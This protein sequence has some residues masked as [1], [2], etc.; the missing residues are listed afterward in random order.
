MS[1]EQARGE[2]VDHRTDIWALGVVLYE[3]LTGFSPFK[4]EYDQA[5]LYSIINEEQE[6]L[7]G[8]CSGVPNKDERYQHTDE[9]L[10]DLKILKKQSE[11]QISTTKP[12]ISSASKRKRPRF[13]PGIIALGVLLILILLY[14]YQKL[15]FHATDTKLP[16]LYN[17]T[18]KQVTFSEDLEE[19]PA[20]FPDGKRLV[21]CRETDR[22]K[23]IFIKNLKTGEE[24][25]LSKGD[26]DD[27]QPTCS[28]GGNIILFVRSNLPAGKLEPGDVYGEHFDGD[29]WKFELNSKKE[30]KLIEN[31]F[32]PSFSPDGFKIAFDAS[33]AGPRRIWIADEFGRNPQ[34]LTFDPSEAVSHVIP[35]WSPDG[36]K[37]VF[38]NIEKNKFDIRTVDI[39]TKE[40]TWITNDSYPDIN[41][42]WSQ[43]GK[44]IYFSSYRSG[45]RNI[46]RVPVTTVGRSAGKAQ[47]VTTGAGE[48]VQ[49]ALSGDGKQM[50]FSILKIN[51]DIW[52]LPVSPQ[53]GEQTGAPQSV[54]ATTREDS[55][56]AWSPDGTQIVFNS[57]RRGDMNI[58]LH[59]IINGST[60]QLTDGPGGDYQPNWSPD[61]K[62]NVFFS[63]RSGNSDIWVVEVETGSLSQ[64]T[65]NA[66]LDMN[67]FF[68]PD[69][70]MI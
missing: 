42:V 9:M 49:L 22:F 41:P 65:K 25:Q 3:M 7:T 32:N 2:D 39:A 18:L 16:A 28:P 17:L 19:Y 68:S 27:I 30:S 4:G 31:A 55:R 1:P 70:R 61:Q 35:R 5:I 64:L 58:W 69:G 11:T 51:A 6:A 67:P 14:T 40:I 57:D 13:Y 53:T 20:F 60:R 23:H 59:S 12:V 29:I 10:T 63:T 54:I 26:Y 36:T 43:S 62:K 48:D 46:W 37:I 24:T 15:F 34:Q 33:W 66:A 52:K 21:Y 50:A 47:Q 38:Q 8:L 56:G 44:A 45:G